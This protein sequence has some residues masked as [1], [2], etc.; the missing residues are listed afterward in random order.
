[1]VLSKD[2]ERRATA[3]QPPAAWV[4]LNAHR[5]ELDVHVGKWLAIGPDG[6]AGIAGPGALPEATAQARA[7]GV[8]EPLV[9]FV[10]DPEVRKS[11]RAR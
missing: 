9:Y 10:Q 5:D 7:A 11:L 1:M 8:I 2:S 6:V 3:W 4:W